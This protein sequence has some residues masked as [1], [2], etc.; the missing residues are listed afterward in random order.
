MRMDFRKSALFFWMLIAALAFGACK[1]SKEKQGKNTEKELPAELAKA[2]REDAARLAV[3]ELLS[4]T[5]TGERGAEIPQER[6]DYFYG[7]LSKIYW[8]AVKDDSIPDL[9]GIHTFK[10]PNLHKIL[11]VLEKDSPFKENWSKGITMTSNL[12]LNQLI[13]KHQL[14]IKDYRVSGLGPTLIMESPQFL[15]TPELAFLIKNFETIRHAEPEGVAGDGND[16]T[17]GSDSK[18]ALALKYSIG[19]GDCPSGCIQR[20]YWIFYVL[21]DG[22]IDYM[23]TRGNIPKE[24][25]PK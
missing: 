16:I 23:G 20:K 5:Q 17:W 24:L 6:I 19:A 12:Y 2:Y 11:V 14:S 10:T 9:S 22:S 21:Q 18:N 25:E 7:L 4:T 3:R 13:A 15:N 1:G 8:M